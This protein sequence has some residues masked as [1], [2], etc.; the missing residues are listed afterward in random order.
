MSNTGFTLFVF[1]ILERFFVARDIKGE[2][3]RNW[4]SVVLDKC[5]M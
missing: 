4:I 1:N 5:I 3:V 2:F